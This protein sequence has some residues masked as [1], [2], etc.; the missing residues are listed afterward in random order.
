MVPLGALVVDLG[1]PL[2]GILDAIYITV[3]LGL[4]LVERLIVENDRAMG[5]ALKLS[6]DDSAKLCISI[7]LILSLQLRLS[8]WFTACSSQHVVHSM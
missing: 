2:D 7:D 1:Q 8:M 5:L 3:T 6:V 4:D